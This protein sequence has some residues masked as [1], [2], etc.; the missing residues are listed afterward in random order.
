MN[1]WGEKL[2]EYANNV[3][4]IVSALVTVVPPALGLL[5]GW[6]E[7]RSLSDLVLLGTA[8]LACGAMLAVAVSAFWKIWFKR[9]V[10]SRWRYVN[11]FR[12]WMAAYLWRGQW[13]REGEGHGESLP[14]FM[15][16]KAAAERGELDSTPWQGAINRLAMVRRDELRRY[17]E[18]IQEYPAFL[19]PERH[20][21]E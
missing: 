3:M 10:I 16:L 1:G 12:L 11:E 8:T 21:E 9:Y 4:G 18:S 5:A 20:P 17:A 15:R 6:F 19:F 14:E 2:G 7:G 13:P